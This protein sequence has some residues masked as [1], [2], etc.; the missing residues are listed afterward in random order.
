MIFYS[1]KW[2]DHRQNDFLTMSAAKFSGFSYYLKQE[3]VIP[4]LEETETSVGFN[5]F[6]I[7]ASLFQTFS[8]RKHFILQFRNHFFS[9]KKPLQLSQS[10]DSKLFLQ[11][12]QSRTK[13]NEKHSHKDEILHVMVPSRKKQTFLVSIL[14]KISATTLSIMTLSITTFSIRTL[15]IR[16]CLCDTQHKWQSA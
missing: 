15:S 8:K 11:L 12:F 6:Q 1:C 7:K 16:S 10:F 4:S 2:N 9:K 14:L 5:S 3:C 13:Y